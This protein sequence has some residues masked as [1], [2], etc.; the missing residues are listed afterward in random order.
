M[1]KLWFSVN[2]A[3]ASPTLFSATFRCVKIVLNTVATESSCC[4]VLINGLFDENQMNGTNNVHLM[5]VNTK[6]RWVNF[7]TFVHTVSSF[8][9]N[10][11]IFQFELRIHKCLFKTWNCWCVATKK[12]K[13]LRKSYRQ[14]FNFRIPMCF[15]ASFGIHLYF[16][17]SKLIKL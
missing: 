7:Q 2:L 5:W 8:T 11:S 14:Q 10:W 4:F 17:T 1:S 15:S 13:M 9:S 3:F 12:L 6:K 16:S